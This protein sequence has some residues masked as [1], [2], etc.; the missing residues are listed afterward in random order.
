MLHAERAETPAA[1][2]AGKKATGLEIV[3]T[4]GV[5]GEDSE[6]EDP[7]EEVEAIEVEAIEVEAIEVEA[8]EVEATEVE[9]TEVEATEVEATEVEATEVEAI[10]AT[11]EEDDDARH[12]VRGPGPGLPDPQELSSARGALRQGGSRVKVEK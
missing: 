8:I 3:L 2:H 5:V 9:A 10:E 7:V 6:E 12:P 4:A 1:L 11:E